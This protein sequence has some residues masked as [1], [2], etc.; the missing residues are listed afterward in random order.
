[1]KPQ[2]V[3]PMLPLVLAF[4][5]LGTVSR[6]AQPP[7]LETAARDFLST[8]AKEDY[9]AAVKN[10]DDTMTKVLPPEKLQAVWKQLVRERG[11]FQKLG[12]T[13]T[14]KLNP[15][16][17]VL[18]TCVFEKGSLKARVVFTAD[19]KITGLFFQPAITYRA[20]A[21]VKQ[22]SF[23]ESEVQIGT[24]EWVLPGTL[25]L[26]ITGGPV[27]AVVLVHGS[28]P[29]DR[30]ESIG[31]NK[32]FRDLAWGLA[33]H[34]VATLRYEKRTKAHRAQAAAL[35]NITIKEEV[36]DDALA[37]VALAQDERHRSR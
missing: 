6:A 24:G 37:A 10:F 31:P 32:P 29:Q 7:A 28:G 36:L 22:G 27:P 12:T 16:T 30:D 4:L 23:R 26:P 33:T 8:L 21:Y 9:A 5:L 3:M 20:P 19:R 34:G 13:E 35:K 2:N 25:T 14:F 17:I 15:Y 18:V 11:T 1:M